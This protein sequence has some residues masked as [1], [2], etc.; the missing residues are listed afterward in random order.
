WSVRK[1][2]TATD[3]A[4]AGE[5]AASYKPMAKMARERA[6]RGEM[7]G[8][9]QDVFSG[10]NFLADGAVILPNLK[11][12]EKGQ[13][14]IDRKLLGYHQHV[15]LLAADTINT[16]YQEISLPEVSVKKRD[17]RL[18]Q[19]ADSK[20]SL[21]EQRQISVIKAGE[22][23]ESRGESAEYNSIARVY[24]LMLTLNNN[25]DLQEF[26]FILR[27]NDSDDK[28]KR[29]WY[30]KYACHELNLFLYHKDKK[31]FDQEILPHL[32]FKKD[33]T[34]MDLWLLGENLETYLA[35]WAFSR[36][37]TA[38]KILLARRLPK[39]R[40]RIVK[41]I[42]QQ[43]EMIPQDNE[44]W[45]RLFDIALSGRAFDAEA[46]GG[47]Q[48]IDSVGEAE[49]MDSDLAMDES[50]AMKSEARTMAAPA[51]PPMMPKLAAEPEPEAMKDKKQMPAGGKE[52]FK[53]RSAERKAVR[54][55]FRSP[56]KTQEWAENNYWHLPIES[57]NADLIKINAFWNEY[58]NSD[59][60]KL[61][62]S[63]N[64]VYA[65]GNFTE[66]ML[67]LAVLDLPITGCVKC[68]VLSV[69]NPV[70]IFHKEIRE[71]AAS[72][73]KIPVMVTRNI[74]KADDRYRYEGNEK[75]DKFVQ[76]EFLLDTAYGCQFLISN[77][78]SSRR[79][80]TAFLQIPEGAIPLNKGFYGKSIPIVLEPYS[81]QLAEYY[82]YFPKPAVS[83]KLRYG[84]PKMKKSWLRLRKS[85]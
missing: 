43:F 35:P 51:P 66:M 59:S 80:F 58:A 55:F 28:Q 72:E 74:F 46:T 8:M 83:G 26:N 6:D 79:R 11:P 45:Y 14:V 4:A 10:M 48:M 1:T 73:E 33:K 7:Q 70:I 27:W 24:Q 54:R 13:I 47:M 57:Q 5:G 3:T 49:E 78:T 34:F 84:F 56:D 75:F 85:H 32:R 40:E 77:P 36:L 81:N 41:H 62:L 37:N 12:D 25:P 38:E 23:S 71:A 69:K 21:T 20:K 64:F 31:F 60:Q 39:E 30:S 16:L 53:G 67:A 63:G 22:K 82:F 19:A 17:L 52:F 2:E 50:A 61:F 9:A 65:A 29:E 76:D 18:A 15:H 68:D 44:T 42:R